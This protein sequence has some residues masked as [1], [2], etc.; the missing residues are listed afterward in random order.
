ML[1]VNEAGAAEAVHVRN[2]G[3][4]PGLH[5]NSETSVAGHGPLTNAALLE[6]K[7]QETNQL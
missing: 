6:A 4:I 7:K 1:A 5:R 2:Y 3:D